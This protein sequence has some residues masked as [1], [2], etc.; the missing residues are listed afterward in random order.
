MEASTGIAA[1][2][3]ASASPW[4]KCL[5]EIRQDDAVG[6]E[7]LMSD[8]FRN[9]LTSTSE[10]AAAEAA[11]QVDTCYQDD[12]LPSDPF[13][14]FL[15]DKARKAKIWNEECHVYEKD[16]ILPSVLDDNWNG[17]FPS[18]PYDPEDPS[19]RKSLEEWVNFSTF[20][21]RCIK[22]GLLDK[23]DGWGRYPA[24][25]IRKALEEN[26]GQG[27]R[28]DCLVMVAAQYLLVAG[29]KIHHQFVDQYAIGSQE[30]Q[31]G[32]EAWGVMVREVA[33]TCGRTGAQA[34][35]GTRG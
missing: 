34:R 17:S 23:F 14:K 2:N 19:S 30:R 27:P 3:D 7:A 28:R 35:S 1:Y 21:A 5:D 4:I 29:N 31:R 26:P 18:H 11:Q 25:E 6:I 24:V 32:L 10:S 9:L 33:G 16:P 20:L 8:I 12:Y 13:M 15:D 22:S